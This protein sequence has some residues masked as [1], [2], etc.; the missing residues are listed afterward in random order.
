MNQKGKTLNFK[1][2][3]KAFMG[4]PNAKVNYNVKIHELTY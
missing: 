2:I 3:I 1:E 4:S